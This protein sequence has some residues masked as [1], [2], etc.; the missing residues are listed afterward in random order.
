MKS[1]TFVFYMCT[2]III[3]YFPLYFES[4]GYTKIEIGT[5]QTIGPIAGIVS[6]LVWGVISDRFHTIKKVLI[7]VLFGQMIMVLLMMQAGSFITLFTVILF[8]FFF[9]TPVNALNDSQIMLAVKGTQK[10]YASFRIWGSLGFAFSSLAV[11]F[12]LGKIGMEQ[13]V[14][15]LLIT[16]AS[17]ILLAF[18]LKDRKGSYKKMEFSG[19][20]QVIRSKAFLLFLLM[21]LI[22]SIAHRTND[23]FTT[24]YLKEL[25]AS[26]GLIGLSPMLAGLSEIPIFL[27]LSKYG[28]KF[29]ELPLL[30]IAG[31]AYGL[32]Y[33]LTGL[34]NDP[35]AVIIVQGLH[36]ISFG[37]FMITAIRYL[38]LLI[39]DEYR[40]TGQAIY[41]VVWSGLAGMANGIAGG[42][43]YK[44]WGST[45]LYLIAA[46][47]G[48]IASCGFLLMHISNLRRS[49]TAAL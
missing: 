3:P 48:F 25:G 34:L 15:I 7:V 28:H 42:W 29:K 2:G 16:T 1:F 23:N 8:F 38:Q 6:N 21:I 14:H 43:V 47:L 24:L 36:S 40:A 19:L 5:L 9:Q 44:E 39:P 11:G 49:E 32:R 35:M 33:L 12:I 30:A 46:A 17:S 13:S 10:S 26:E 37:I 41:A 27:L 20:V 31:L 18:G 45:T 22:I 4:Q